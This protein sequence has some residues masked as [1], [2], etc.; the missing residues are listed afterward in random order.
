MLLHG[1]QVNTQDAS[2]RTALYWSITHLANK[3]VIKLLLDYGANPNIPVKHY[4]MTT[5]ATA[6]E[7]AEEEHRP[8]IIALLR[9]YSKNP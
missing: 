2:G 9:K 5:T 7:L 8:D 3:N 6:I 4:K 1:A